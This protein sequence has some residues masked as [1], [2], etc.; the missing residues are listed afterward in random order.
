[1]PRSSREKSA[2]TRSRIIDAAYCL[3]VSKGY[4]ATPMR[5]VSQKAGVT[6]GAIYNHFATKEDIWVAVIHEKHPYHEILPLILT[7]RGDTVSEIIRSA[8]RLMVGELL[9]RPDLFNL[10]FIEI[11]EFKAVHVP[12]LYEEIVPTLFP[13]QKLFEGKTGSLRDIPLPIVLRSFVGLFFSYYI[14]G[15]L[16]KNLPGV[17]TDEKSLDLFVDLYLNGILKDDD[18]PHLN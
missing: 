13:M 15:I 9:N 10:M 17:A 3:F 4:N 2:E 1:M 16:L 12:D 8:A 7:A 6:V 18:L 14:T 5:E 11:V